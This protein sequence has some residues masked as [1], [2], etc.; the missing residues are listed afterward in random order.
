MRHGDTIG[1]VAPASPYPSKEIFDKGISYLESRGYRVKPGRSVH[2]KR[3]Y[4]AGGDSDRLND[5][6]T[7][8]SDPEVRAIIAVRGG[9]GCGRLVRYI[10]YGLIRENP[11]IFVGYSDLTALQLAIF[12]QTRMITYGGPMVSA[13]LGKGVDNDTESHFWDTLCGL[14]PHRILQFDEPPSQLYNVASFEGTLLGGNLALITS[15]IGTPYLPDWNDAVL[16]LEEIGEAPYRIDR[17]L[18]QLRL[19]GILTSV[20]AVLLGQ[21]TD[22]I[23]ANGNPTLSLEEVFE[24]H[25]GDLGIPV[26]SGISFGHEKTKLTMPWGGRVLY[27]VEENVIHIR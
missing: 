9:Y 14:S 11:K 12:S 19:S 26:L 17:M 23:Q 7:M 10:D 6:H 15:M 13:D 22:C 16:A 5:L 2:L 18:N 25:L 20:R 27:K 4:L 8:F 24:D 1:I 21:F 3:G